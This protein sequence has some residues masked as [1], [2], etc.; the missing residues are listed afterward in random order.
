MVDAAPMHAPPATP[1]APTSS[2]REAPSALNREAA[3]I[4]DTATS[5]MTGSVD[6]GPREI[7]VRPTGLRHGRWEAPAWAF[8]TIGGVVLALAIVYTLGRVGIIDLSRFSRSRRKTP[9]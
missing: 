6:T 4:P 1:P 3:G 2:F 7:I 8:W 5:S 9:G